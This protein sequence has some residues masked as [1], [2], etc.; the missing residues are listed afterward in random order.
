M[1]EFLQVFCSQRQ[2]ADMLQRTVSQLGRWGTAAGIFILLFSLM[3]R[4]SLACFFCFHSSLRGWDQKVVKNH[5][6]ACLSKGSA[7]LSAILFPS[8]RVLILQKM[9]FCQNWGLARRYRF[10]LESQDNLDW[11]QR[12]QAP[13]FSKPRKGNLAGNGTKIAFAFLDIES[14]SGR[15]HTYWVSF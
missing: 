5:A 6:M 1:C 15:A 11:S 14:V 7:Q 2:C 8:T 3:L 13:C 4:Y 10:S 12:S 9:C